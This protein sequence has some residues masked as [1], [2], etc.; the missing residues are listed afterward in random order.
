[1][2]EKKIPVEEKVWQIYYRRKFKNRMFINRLSV[3][4]SGIIM[5]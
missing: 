1:M 3:C 2:L 4:F 5:V